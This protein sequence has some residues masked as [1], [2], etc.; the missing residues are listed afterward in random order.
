MKHLLTTA[1]I[2]TALASPV[3]AQ[4]SLI[5]VVDRKFDAQTGENYTPERLEEL[6]FGAIVDLYD[7]TLSRCSFVQSAGRVTCDTY[8]IDRMEVAARRCDYLGKR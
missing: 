8:P 7:Q 5:C 3:F 2:A 1:L 4:E 6:Q